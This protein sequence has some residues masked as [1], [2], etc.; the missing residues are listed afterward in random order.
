MIIPLTSRIKDEDAKYCALDLFAT[1]LVIIIATIVYSI[2]PM[3][4]KPS[5][6]DTL[7]DILVSVFF[8]ELISLFTAYSVISHYHRKFFQKWEWLIRLLDD[9]N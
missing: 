9:T 8:I 1:I 5:N 6:T 3:I 4:I 2:L 7:I